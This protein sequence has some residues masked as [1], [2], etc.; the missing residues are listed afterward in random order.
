M[1]GCV[2]H[3]FVLFWGGVERQFPRDWTMSVTVEAG[4]V[5]TPC[6]GLF[7]PIDPKLR[8]PVTTPSRAA[9]SSVSCLGCHH[10]TPMQH[11]Q[12]GCPNPITCMSAISA[13]KVAKGR[14][15]LLGSRAQTEV[16]NG[17]LERLF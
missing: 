4:A 10:R 13:Q 16:R 2:E 11:W 9:V 1:S 7:G 12:D 14:E 8:L 6:M 5:G 15:L 3:V 17:G